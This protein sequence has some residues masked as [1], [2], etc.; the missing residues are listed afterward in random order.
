MKKTS[1]TSLFII[2]VLAIL[3]GWVLL[4]QQLLHDQMSIL[5]YKPSSQML[6][7]RNK[8]DLTPDGEFYF[9]ASQPQLDNAQNFNQNCRQQ[10]ETNNPILGC[11]VN[12]RMYVFN[13]T[14]QELDGIKETTAAHE[15]LHAV[16]QRLSAKERTLLNKQI[17]AAYHNL[18]DATLKKRVAYYEKTEPGEKYNELHS[19]LGSEYDNIGPALEAY[20]Q[21]YFRNRHELL[22]YHNQYETV[23]RR[24]TS[25]MTS[26][27]DDI[28]SSTKNIND[29]LKAYNMQSAQL[30]G[31]IKTFNARSQHKG[32]FVSQA[33]FQSERQGLLLRQTE[34][35]NV[36][37]SINEQI[38]NENQKR[39]QYNQLVKQ[40]NYLNDSINSTLA[41]APS[42]K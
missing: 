17:D 37:N 29:Q 40:Y 22:R 13:I 35:L 1:Y 21:K 23:F 36:R 31:N 6:A 14:N 34:L 38:K 7:I 26:L 20:Y 41:P 33:E 2:L 19:I 12:N 25:Q 28:N 42:L 18:K 8:L 15:M 11:Y 27:S 30:E 3:T 39:D 16:Y 24:I 9:N 32:N 10:R 4:N 5:R